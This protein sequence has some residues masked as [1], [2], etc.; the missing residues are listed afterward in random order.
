VIASDRKAKRLGTALLVVDGTDDAL[1]RKAEIAL[2]PGRVKA[3]SLSKLVS[4]SR[5]VYNA[6]IEHRRDAWRLAKVTVTRFDEFSEIADLRVLRPDMAA[7]GSRFVRGAISRADEAYAAFFRRLGDGETPGYPR[8]KSRK[9]FRTVFYDEPVGWAIRRLGDENSAHSGRPALYVQGVG[10]M[11]L[12][13]SASRQL[14]RFVRRGGEPRT[15]TIT[16]T[17][18]GAWRACVGFRD[19]SPI[20]LAATGQVGGVDRGITVTAA[21]SD[22]TLL[23]MPSFVADARDEIAALSR[24]RE[25]SQKFGPEW[26]QINKKIAKAYR[27]AHHRSENWARHSAIKIVSRYEVIS[28]EALKLQNMTKSA[29]GTKESPGR[30]VAA[31][32]GLNRSLSDAALSRLAYWIQVKAEEAGRRVYK[33]DPRNSS[34]ECACCGNTEVANRRRTRFSCLRCGYS[35]HADV[36]AAQVIAIRGR[37]ADAIWVASGSP[38]LTRPIPRNRR[39]KGNATEQHGAGS[40]PHAQVA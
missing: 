15:L 16:K 36:N 14:Q 7:Y 37:R 11:L 33:V 19:V 25:K 4:L 23:S 9:R 18:S 24:K 22:G 38:P 32:Q 21:L 31:K 30:N 40:A 8:F 28:I 20:P 17:T 2:L 6:S 26:K 10:E 1:N 3:R 29:S 35:G 5:E 13:T 12:S 27:R 34:R 39:R